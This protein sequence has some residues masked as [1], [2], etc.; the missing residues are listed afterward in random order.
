MGVNVHIIYFKFFTQQKKNY[1]IVNVDIVL[2]SSW[3][4]EL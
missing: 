3:P 1:F 2:K 4:Y